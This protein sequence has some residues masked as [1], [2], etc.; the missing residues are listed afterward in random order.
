VLLQ[1]GTVIHMIDQD[2]QGKSKMRT[3][4]RYV[5]GNCVGVVPGTVTS[6]CWDIGPA[7]SRRHN[8]CTHR[9]VLTTGSISPSTGT[10]VPYVHLYCTST[11]RVPDL[12]IVIRSITYGLVALLPGRQVPGS[13]T[14][15]ASSCRHNKCTRRIVLT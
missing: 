5:E 2:L 6:R 1:H 15:P 9:L 14:R 11:T 7:S 3:E 13:H 10:R 4:Y 8:K 12:T